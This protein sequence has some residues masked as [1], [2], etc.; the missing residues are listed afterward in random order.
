MCSMHVSKPAKLRLPGTCAPL[1]TLEHAPE[2]AWK[3]NASVGESSLW[4]LNCEVDS[5]LLHG[6][7]W[8]LLVHHLPKSVMDHEVG[9]HLLAGIDQFIIQDGEPLAR[10]RM[11]RS[12]HNE[13]AADPV[14]N[15]INLSK[16]VWLSLK[17]PQNLPKY[18]WTLEDNIMKNT[19]MHK[20]EMS[21]QGVCSAKCRQLA[22]QEG[23]IGPHLGVPLEDKEEPSDVSA[24]FKALSQGITGDV[25]KSVAS[26]QSPPNFSNKESLTK[27]E[28]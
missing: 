24:C 4:S 17:G 25:Q 8:R 27:S 7:T 11:A 1:N 5:S 26:T 15:D 3:K 19:V 10:Q 6:E 13:P 16:L 23:V 28:R 20:E 21:A 14:T 2:L 9:H 22:V 12:A 18:H